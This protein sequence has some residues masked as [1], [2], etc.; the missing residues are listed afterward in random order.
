[1]SNER[2]TDRPPGLTDAML[3]F[4]DGL[5]K[6]DVEMPF[7]ASPFLARAFDMDMETAR[8]YVRY[9]HMTYGSRHRVKARDV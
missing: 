3:E 4:L 2:T 9:W 8:T 5:R 1:M 7:G 6:R